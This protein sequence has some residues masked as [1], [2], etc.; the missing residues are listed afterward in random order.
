LNLSIQKT[1]EDRVTESAASE[2][3][4]CADIGELEIREFLN[5]LVGSEAIGQQIEDITNSDTHAS[6]AGSAG[7]LLGIDGNPFFEVCHGFDSQGGRTRSC[8]SL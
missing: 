7:A 4:T 2:M 5:D 6:N 3:Q 8:H 1:I